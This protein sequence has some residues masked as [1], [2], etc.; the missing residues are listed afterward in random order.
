LIVDH[1]F[2]CAKCRAPRVV[3]VESSGMDMIVG[4]NLKLLCQACMAAMPATPVVTPGVDKILQQIPP[5]FRKTDLSRLPHQWQ[6]LRSWEPTAEGLYLCGPTRQFKSRIAYAIALKQMR[7]GRRVLL[8]DGRSLRG[9]I[10]ASIMD[11][12]LWPWYKHVTER[13]DIVL[14]DDL[15]K[16]RGEGRRIEEELFNL[17]KLCCDSRIPLIITS[18]DTLSELARHYSPGISE[19]LVARLKERCRVVWF[20]DETQR[21]RDAITAVVDSFRNADL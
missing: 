18:N 21:R 16:F 4:L 19:P 15:G 3:K 7:S 5:D 13:Y 1:E 6:T 9:H 17:I 10:E 14:I 8:H 12:T 20:G 2:I 11:G